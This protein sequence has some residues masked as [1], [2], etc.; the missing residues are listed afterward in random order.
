MSSGFISIK[1]YSNETVEWGF[2]AL[3]TL[4]LQILQSI[5][6]TKTLFETSNLIIKLTFFS[7]VCFVSFCRRNHSPLSFIVPYSAYTKVGAF[8]TM[9]N[10][11]T[12]AIKMSNIHFLIVF[13]VS[14]NSF[15]LN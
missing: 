4:K 9:S 14:V 1:I 8:Q 13:D 7:F 2:G 12:F 5:D 10:V 3:S 11:L 6:T 15:F